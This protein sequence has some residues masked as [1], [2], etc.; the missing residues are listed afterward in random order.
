MN[1]IHHK[2][3]GSVQDASMSTLKTDRSVPILCSG[4]FNSERKKNNVKFIK[5]FVF[6][7][8]LKSKVH[9][10]LLLQKPILSKSMKHAQVTIFSVYDCRS[11]E[12]YGLPT[13]GPMNSLEILLPKANIAI[14]LKSHIASG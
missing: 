13:I 9:N 8:H 3:S 4:T 6:Q 10:V 2:F 1:S 7:L 12:I 11:Q 14:F 5:A